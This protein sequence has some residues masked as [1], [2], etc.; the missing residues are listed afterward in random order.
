M[1]LQSCVCYKQFVNSKVAVSA[2]DWWHYM[3]TFSISNQILP[4]WAPM[5]TCVSNLE[6]VTDRRG[7]S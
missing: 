5:R 6:D 3:V 4:A 7:Q 1:Q 2:E